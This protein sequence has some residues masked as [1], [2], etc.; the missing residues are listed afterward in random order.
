MK[1]TSIILSVLMIAGYLPARRLTR[2]R[3]G[4]DMIPVQ[5]ILRTRRKEQPAPRSITA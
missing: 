3:R 2:R 1:K 4:K 5:Y